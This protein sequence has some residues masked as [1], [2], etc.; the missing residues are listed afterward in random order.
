MLGQGH[1]YLGKLLI[2]LGN[3]WGE[4]MGCQAANGGNPDLTR[5]GGSEGDRLL[6]PLLHL[7][8]NVTSCT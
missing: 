5:L 2:K 4:P 3:N 8:Q 6:S 1:G 7:G